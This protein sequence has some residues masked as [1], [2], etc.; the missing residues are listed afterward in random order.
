MTTVEMGP[1]VAEMAAPPELVFQML[2]AIGQGAQEHG[3]KAELVEEDAQG[4]IFDFWTWIALPLGRGRLM[5]TRE[6]VRLCPPARIEYEHLDGPLRGLEEAIDVTAAAG[7][8][9]RLVYTGTY[10][11]K[12]VFDRLATVLVSRPVLHHVMRA[13]FASVGARAEARARR[14]RLFPSEWSQE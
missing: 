1:V 6:R 2:A 5:R 12:G 11:A 14:S 10:R 7:T 8:G 4:L 9:T 3:E 13:H